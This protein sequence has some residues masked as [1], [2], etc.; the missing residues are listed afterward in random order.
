MRS[1]MAMARCWFADRSCVVRLSELET[2]VWSTRMAEE[3]ILGSEIVF[4]M[5]KT[6][7]SSALGRIWRSVASRFRRLSCSCGTS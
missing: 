7:W 1:T 6:F 5:Q 2:L 4:V 3:R